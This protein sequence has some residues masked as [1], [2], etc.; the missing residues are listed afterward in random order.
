MKAF[1]PKIE[2]FESLGLNVSS[3]FKVLGRKESLL[4]MSSNNNIVP[5]VD[6]LRVFFAMDSNFVSVLKS[7]IIVLNVSKILKPKIS[8]LVSCGVPRN[9]IKM[10]ILQY[11]RCF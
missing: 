11:P 1:K 10:L 6:F 4:L 5:T 7:R 9:G 3:F 8:I 2:Y